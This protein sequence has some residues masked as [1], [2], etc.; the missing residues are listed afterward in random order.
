MRISFYFLSTCSLIF[1][2]FFVI[3]LDSSA[4]TDAGFDSGWEERAED[5]AERRRQDMRVEQNASGLLTTTAVRRS[6]QRPA[7][8]QIVLQEEERMF[9]V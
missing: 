7:A 8:P 6:V 9:C 1:T 3:F 4:E 2:L 5:R